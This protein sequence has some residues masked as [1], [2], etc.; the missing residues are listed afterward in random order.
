[1]Y[2]RQSSQDM[3]SGFGIWR[4]IF[5]NGYLHKSKWSKERLL[6]HPNELYTIFAAKDEGNPASLPSRSPCLVTALT[7]LTTTYLLIQAETSA[8]SELPLGV[9]VRTRLRH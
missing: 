5:R 4:T 9:S 8:V 1:M 3:Y 7:P 6:V 2:A